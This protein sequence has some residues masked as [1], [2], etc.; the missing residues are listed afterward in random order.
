MY[1]GPEAGNSWCVSGRDF[2]GQDL[3]PHHSIRVYWTSPQ[4]PV[5]CQEL[6]GMEIICIYVCM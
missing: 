2:L 1:G 5:L 3:V 4:G 6:C